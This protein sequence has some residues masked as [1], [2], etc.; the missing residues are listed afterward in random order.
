MLVT[1]L[2]GYKPNSLQAKNQT[3]KSLAIPPD[4]VTENSTASEDKNKLLT[5]NS[6]EAA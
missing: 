6:T 2:V 1:L 5:E 3:N 4:L